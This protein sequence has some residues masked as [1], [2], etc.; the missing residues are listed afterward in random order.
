MDF[1]FHL[2]QDS[3]RFIP[4]YT[5]LYGMITVDYYFILLSIFYVL[6]SF[7][8]LIFKYLFK[9]LYKYTNS[10]SLPLLGIGERPP[11]AYVNPKIGYLDEL[12][13]EAKLF[14]MPS[15]H[16]QSAWFFCVFGLLYF[17]DKVYYGS[18]L[19]QININDSIFGNYSVLIKNKTKQIWLLLV[20]LLMV[21]LATFISYSRV[22]N[23]YHT[24]QQVIVGG[25]IGSILGGVF[26]IISKY[27]IEKKPIKFRAF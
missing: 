23:N 14:G 20:I 13:F 5:F 8:N 17:M 15:G 26:Y 7:M 11:G 19:N 1:A 22:H 16:A 24:V 3:P 18:K 4:I 10:K 21:G 12:S 2:A 27:I 9:L 6:S 25:I